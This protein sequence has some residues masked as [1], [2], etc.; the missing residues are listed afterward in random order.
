MKI[1]IK[2]HNCGKVDTAYV[3]AMDWDRFSNLGELVQNVW[4]DRDE[5][6]REILIGARVGFYTCG[7]CWDEL[8]TE[9][10]DVE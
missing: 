4:P 3:D 10:E 2:C 8:F 5:N 1:E 9:E 6:E 7:S